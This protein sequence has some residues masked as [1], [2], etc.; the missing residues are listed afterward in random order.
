VEITRIEKRDTGIG[1]IYCEHRPAPDEI[2]AQVLT[3][4]FHIV[5]TRREPGPVTFDRAR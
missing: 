2:V 5:R 1:V 3:M 4:P